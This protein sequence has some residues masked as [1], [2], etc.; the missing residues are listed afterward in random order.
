MTIHIRITIFLYIFKN[1]Y[2]L[3]G[4]VTLTEASMSKTFLVTVCPNNNTS[5]IS[6]N[7]FWRRS[8]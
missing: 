8:P 6:A 5:Q 7:V 4:C 2:R 3:Q 1:N